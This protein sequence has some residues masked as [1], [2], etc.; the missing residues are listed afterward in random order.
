VLRG[1]EEI[2]ESGMLFLCAP[3]R[4]T[5]SSNFLSSNPH[6]FWFAT[7]E[8]GFVVVEPDEDDG[9]ARTYRDGP[10]DWDVVASVI[11]DISSQLANIAPDANEATVTVPLS[12]ADSRVEWDVVTGWFEQ[13][14]EVFG[15]PG[16]LANGR[17]RL[18]KV[19]CASPDAV[20]PIRS[21]AAALSENP[22]TVLEAAPEGIWGRNP[23]LHSWFLD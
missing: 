6:E 5:L 4:P 13:R 11:S 8:D 9:R 23:V 18:W 15:D 17:H 22:A 20:L 1:E 21:M 2:V 19:W 12:L 16:N 14:D 7:R 3:P 10:A